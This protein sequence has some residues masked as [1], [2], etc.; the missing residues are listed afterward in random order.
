MIRPFT[1]SGAPSRAERTAGSIRN[2]SHFSSESKS[3][4]NTTP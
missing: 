3:T 2:A 4:S 1:G